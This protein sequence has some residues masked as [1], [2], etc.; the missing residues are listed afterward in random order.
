MYFNCFDRLPRIIKNEV[1]F[2]NWYE[3]KDC[4]IAFSD[5]PKISNK[6]IHNKVLTKEEIKKAKKRPLYLE[7]DITVLLIDKVKSKEYIFTV[8]KY[9][10]YDGASV[11]RIFW[12]LIG[13]KEDIRFKIASLVHDVICTNKNYVEYDRRFS[14]IVFERL[15]RVADTDKISRLIMFLA[16][17]VYQIFKNWKT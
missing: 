3:D 10:D 11:W 6:Q 8:K 2:Y 13:S 16:V 17:E 5:I 9:F 4:I 7:N 1:V 12:R 14:S 15:L